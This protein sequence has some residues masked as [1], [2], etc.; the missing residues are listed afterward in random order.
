[1][2]VNYA[3][4]LA[5][6][7]DFSGLVSTRKEGFS[8][9]NKFDVEYLFLGR[10]RHSILRLFRLCSFVKKNKVDVIHA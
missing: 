5:D 9:S 6:E 10:K 4:A 3:N 8:K 1:M 2:A 7:I